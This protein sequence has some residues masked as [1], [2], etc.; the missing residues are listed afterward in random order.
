[1]YV[2]SNNNNK[3]IAMNMLSILTANLELKLTILYEVS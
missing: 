3:T 2:A 1:M